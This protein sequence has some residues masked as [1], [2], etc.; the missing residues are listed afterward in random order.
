MN[1]HTKG[2]WIISSSVLVVS[3]DAHVIANT[4]SMIGV[5]DLCINIFEAEANARLIAAA[6]D[7]LAACEMMLNAHDTGEAEGSP[8]IVEK[9][10][11]AI[12]KAKP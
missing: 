6:P 11:E 2:K 3:E 8:R 1:E 4:M 9:L 10:R 5:P 12:A 7:L